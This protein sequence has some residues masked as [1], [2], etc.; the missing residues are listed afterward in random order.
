MTDN[1]IQINDKWR[2]EVDPHNFIPCIYKEPSEIQ[3]GKFK[4]Q[5][6]KGGYERIGYYYPTLERALVGIV[7]YESKHSCVDGSDLEVYIE[8]VRGL[9]QDILGFTS[10]EPSSSRGAS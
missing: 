5:L 8:K 1:Y 4:G 3:V 7:Q 9:W 6:S 10:T 2:V